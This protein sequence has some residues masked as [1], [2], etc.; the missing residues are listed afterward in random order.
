MPMI[1]SHLVP[2]VSAVLSRQ[3]L[4]LNPEEESQGSAHRGLGASLS[5]TLIVP[6]PSGP[7]PTTL[8]GA[9]Q[10]YGRAN[11]QDESREKRPGQGPLLEGPCDRHLVPLLQ[12]GTRDIRAG[13]PHLPLMTRHLRTSPPWHH[14]C[15]SGGL[16][17][18]LSPSSEK[19][20]TYISGISTGFLPTM[21]LPTTP[22][23]SRSFPLSPP[24]PPPPIFPVFSL[25]EI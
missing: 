6:P 1:N 23:S 22:P 18:V 2:E 10:I 24:N 8:H 20:A 14:Q 16:P 15:R 19:V 4:M 9:R 11:P 17:L 3:A 5:P 7:S 13:Y 21:F 12:S 25:A